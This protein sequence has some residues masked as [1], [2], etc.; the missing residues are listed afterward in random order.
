MII[1]ADSFE[2]P[3]ACNSFLKWSTS[4]VASFYF[5]LRCFSAIGT[6]KDLV[7]REGEMVSVL[8]VEAIGDTT[9]AFSELG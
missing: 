2:I 9:I 7:R 4:G 3:S 8:R 6:G 1:N 5:T